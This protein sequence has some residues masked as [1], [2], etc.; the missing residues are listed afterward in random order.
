MLSTAQIERA[1][2]TP[3]GEVIEARGLKLRGRIE[4]VGPCPICGGTDRFAVNIRKNLFN[5]RGCNAGGDAIAL[6]QHLDGVSF[7]EAC[8]T[9]AGEPPVSARSEP[10]PIIKPADDDTY[11]RQQGRKAR[12]LFRRSVPASGTLA[13]TYLRSRGITAPMPATVRFLA[14][15]SADHRP[16]MVVPFGLPDEP[17]PAIL[18]IDDDA[19]TAV[20]LTLLRPDGSG[21]AD[22]RPNKLVIGSPGGIPLVLAPLN[23][24][25][26]LAITEGIEDA[27][28]AH[29][30]TGLGAWAAGSAGFMPKLIAA[31]ED[32]AA[33]EYDASPECVT[34][35]A[36]SDDAGQRGA[37]QLA[38][39]LVARGIE[40][41]VN[42][43]SP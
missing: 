34:I 43:L 24:L 33:R 30:A 28:S 26:G 17:E 27:L 32:L 15:I 1:R 2:S 39:A 18:A 6:V 41:F 22:A 40:T 38:E 3:I 5:C 14:P 42:G 8:A 11:E 37:R 29:Q 13:E 19:I 21:K 25:L 12:N 20:H 23:D 10:R 35:F 36:D 9:L 16:A 31:I 7:A 4:R